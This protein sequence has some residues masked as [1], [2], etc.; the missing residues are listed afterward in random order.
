MLIAL[1]PGNQRYINFFIY[2][3]K[4]RICP[5]NLLRYIKLASYKIIFQNEHDF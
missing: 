4:N 2:L 1:I 5:S 3:K